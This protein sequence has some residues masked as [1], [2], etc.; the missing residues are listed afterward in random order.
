MPRFRVIFSRVYFILERIGFALKKNGFICR[1]SGLFVI[2]GTILTSALIS[3]NV[4]ALPA[5]EILDCLKT[6]HRGTILRINRELRKDTFED[7]ISLARIRADM[8]FQGFVSEHC[9]TP[10]M[11]DSALFLSLLNCIYDFDTG[12][13]NRQ[14]D[15]LKENLLQHVVSMR[16]PEEFRNDKYLAT[17]FDLHFGSHVKTL[18]KQFHPMSRPHSKSHKKTHFEISME[19]SL[20]P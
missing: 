17:A 18:F 12:S 1:L 5:E 2:T 20:T 8:K 13:R 3:Q 6:E 11:V 7:Y 14:V 15:S 10:E 9:G 19:L 16:S 4:F